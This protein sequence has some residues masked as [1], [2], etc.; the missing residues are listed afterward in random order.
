[1]ITSRLAVDSETYFLVYRVSG[2]HEK[3]ESFELYAAEPVFD[4]CG[5]STIEPLFSDSI[6]DKNR[7][8]NNQYVKHVY[9]APPN[10]LVF[11]YDLGS[12]PTIGHHRKL[13]LELKSTL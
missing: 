9:F 1:M 2:W 10:R 8:N 13:T 7:N 3:V 4:K 6:D 12:Q 11:D 5:I